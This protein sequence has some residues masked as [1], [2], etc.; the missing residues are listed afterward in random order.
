MFRENDYIVVLTTIHHQFFKANYIFKQREDR[1]YLC[2]EKDCE[3]DLN[4][5]TIIQYFKSSYWRYATKEEIE[6]YK[7]LNYPFDVTKLIN[8]KQ[9]EKGMKKIM[10]NTLETTYKNLLLRRNTVPLFMSNPGIGKSTIVK[11]FAEERGVTMK[12]ITLSQRMPNE[13]VGMMMPDVSTNSMLVFDSHELSS[14]K[15]GDILFVDEAFNGTLKQTLD[16][17]LNLI[18]D[19]ILPSG[20]KLADIMI[21]AASNPQGLIN[22]T[23]QIK[24]RFIR[25]DLKFNDNEYKEYL[26]YKYGMPYEIGSLICTLIKREKYEIDTWNY[27]SPRSIEK[28][29]LQIACGLNTTYDDVLM[30]C[31]VKT[32]KSPMDITSLSVKEGDEVQ[33]L[34]ILKLLIININ[35]KE[36]RKQENRVADNLLS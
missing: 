35:D 12:K 3:G 19:R 6:E 29:I 2:V 33:Y 30:P 5:T 16:A 10:L 31:L 1:D 9:E 21:V 17:F 24:E 4:G 36:N 23:P 13:V 7:E 34:D 15:D 32:I 20:K 11:Q 22:L 26:N 8:K 18:E 25:I 27:S 14:L 28:A